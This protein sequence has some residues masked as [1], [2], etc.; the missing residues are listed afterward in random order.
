M[1]LETSTM[2]VRAAVAGGASTRALA[3]VAKRAAAKRI[4]CAGAKLRAPG[5]GFGIG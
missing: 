5:S 1:L 3:A 2:C 4:W